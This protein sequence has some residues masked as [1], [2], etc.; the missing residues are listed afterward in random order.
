MKNFL[1]IFFI[2][3]FLSH[4]S[5]QEKHFVFI[6]SDTKQPFYVSL[7]NRLYSSTASGYVIIP[8]LTNGN[9][10]FSIGFAQNAY[11]EQ[12][13]SCIVQDKDLGY[14][15]KNFNEKG[16]GLF[17]LQSLDIT[18][19]STGGSNLVAKALS[20]NS[21]ISAPAAVISFD[22]KKETS[23]SENKISDS[24]V[25]LAKN[26][27][28]KKSVS[29][30]DTASAAN[31]KISPASSA[32]TN[33]T[34]KGEVVIPK[35]NQNADIRK[36]GEVAGDEGVLLSYVDDK[37]KDTIKVII[38]TSTASTNVS[39][40]SNSNINSSKTNVE[41]TNP[42]NNNSTSN[43]KKSDVKFLD[44]NIEK[45]KDSAQAGKA[46]QENSRILENSN[47]KNFATDEDYAKLR[48]K[49]ATETSDE[50]MISEAKKFYRNK[51]FTTRQIKGLSSL[52][53]S[54]EGRFKFFDA[55]FVS[56]ADAGQYYTLQSELI[57]PAFVIRFKAL[58]Q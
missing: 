44:I 47:C 20:E 29:S 35:T 25:V 19:A 23:Q 57:D 21:N 14:N 1:S 13:F 53:A 33:E 5:A 55:S 51:C 26:E 52:F 4:V 31:S 43:T 2:S 37:A 54:D 56:A 45:G 10:N 38:P 18:M 16:W 17:N 50:K 22:K 58:L 30:A 40:N 32:T 39:N 8:K 34:T 24:S 3:F 36:V 28:A 42:I 46:P 11:P 49:M 9:Y 41:V 27:D 7:N 15:L 48:R 6:Q 12:S